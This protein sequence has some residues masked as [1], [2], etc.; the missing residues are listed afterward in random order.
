MEQPRRRQPRALGTFLPV[1]QTIAQTE[2][3]GLLPYRPTPV[4]SV[5][6]GIARALLPLAMV[7]QARAL[8][9]ERQRQ[10]R[11][12]ELAPIIAQ[13]P[14]GQ[15]PEQ[16][17]R[18]YTQ[19]AG[20][21]APP[22]PE[23]PEAALRRRLMEL[24]VTRAERFLPYEEEQMKL[25]IQQIQQGL[26]KGELDIETAQERLRQMREEWDFVRQFRGLELERLRAENRPL[27]EVAPELV[28]RLPDRLKGLADLPA[29]QVAMLN[30]S[31]ILGLMVDE[32]VLPASQFLTESQKRWLQERGINPDQI[33]FGTLVKV[34]PDV[35]RA[36]RTVKEAF[37]DRWQ[38]VVQQY[39]F[40]EA[41]GDLPATP[42]IIFSLHDLYI[43][44][45][46]SR[47][48]T[49]RQLYDDVLRRLSEAQQKGA[50]ASLVG[51]WIAQHNIL[52]RELGLPEISPQEA[53]Q[54]IGTAATLYDINVKKQ[55]L[56]LVKTQVDIQKG[57]VSMRT[58]EANAAANQARTNAY[59]A[60][61]ANLI[62]H[63]QVQEAQKAQEQAWKQ[64]TGMHQMVEQ[65]LQRIM[66]TGQPVTIQ[67]QGQTYHATFVKGLG[68]QLRR[69]DGT[70]IPAHQVNQTAL[71]Q[72]IRQRLR[73][74]VMVELYPPPS[75]QLRQPQ[76]PAPQTPAQRI[77]QGKSTQQP[78]QRPRVIGVRRE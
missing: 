36:T 15:V 10:Q 61:V 32:F 69:P 21:E 1:L 9:Q 45:E 63:R 53:Q 41:M 34:M 37:G 49:A 48:Q 2:D 3:I 44:D 71:S 24:E 7:R 58:M 5:L 39:P 42:E 6:S 4:A 26:V 62:Q 70:V 25:G 75:Q 76:R 19:L 27:R 78:T 55:S 30:Q 23:P 50:P 68:W 74:E 73:D 20:V 13:Y 64:M 17:W 43:K 57:I 77:Q 38:R 12:A 22:P 59:I 65:R 33:S 52:A 29:W 35:F 66:Q 14:A 54:I 51:A 16:L 47:K 11:L 67:W 28:Q 46:Q 40:V 31:G 56:S 72:L 18:E 8:E 60:N